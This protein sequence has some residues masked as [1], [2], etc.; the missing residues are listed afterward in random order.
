MVSHLSK[1]RE[2]RFLNM[3]PEGRFARSGISPGMVGKLRVFF[4]MMA[5][6]HS[7]IFRDRFFIDSQQ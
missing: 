2:Q 4:S 3:H 6:S 7:R 5:G 1:D